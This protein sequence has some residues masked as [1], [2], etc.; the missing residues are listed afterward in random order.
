M[1]DIWTDFTHSAA[2]NRQYNNPCFNRDYSILE[3]KTRIKQSNICR[4]KSPWQ[5][6][7]SYILSKL[8]QILYLFPFPLAISR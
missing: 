8:S 5:G 1:V 2:D 7:F 4:A 6:F 3:D